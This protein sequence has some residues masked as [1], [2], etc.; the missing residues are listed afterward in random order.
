M[1]TFVPGTGALSLRNDIKTIAVN[2]GCSEGVYTDISLSDMDLNAYRMGSTPSGMGEFYGQGC[3]A[4]IEVYANFYAD[5]Y[6]DNPASWGIWY[7]VGTTGT[8]TLICSGDQIGINPTC[9]GPFTVYI[10]T[11]DGIGQSG[12]DVWVGVRTQGKSVLSGYYDAQDTGGCPNTSPGFYIGTYDY[13]CA[14]VYKLSGTSGAV[15]TFYITISVDKAG[16]VIA[17]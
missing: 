8:E 15:T 5:P 7:K 4:I 9:T 11:K 16:Y 13:A 3:P 12:N 6:S 2:N 17:C 14:D 10:A 1:P